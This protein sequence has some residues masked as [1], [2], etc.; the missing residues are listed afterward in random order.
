MEST[1]NNFDETTGTA[2]DNYSPVVVHLTLDAGTAEA[3]RLGLPAIPRG[4]D[5]REEVGS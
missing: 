4:S 1:C 2:D 5:S 3:E